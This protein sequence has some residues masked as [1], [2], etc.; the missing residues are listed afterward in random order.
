MTQ[1]PEEVAYLWQRAASSLEA[2]AVLIERGLADAVANRAYYAVFYAVSAL[3]LT[4]GESF[5]KHTAVRAHLHKVYVK[6]GRLPQEVGS[7]YD[8]LFALRDVG[9]YG[10]SKHVNTAEAKE[11]ITEARRLLE[12][13]R[14]LLPSGVLDQH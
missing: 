3:F 4:E 9:D 2:A 12:A 14:E 11:A 7:I 10:V 5:P 1:Y 13:V 6:P 8:S